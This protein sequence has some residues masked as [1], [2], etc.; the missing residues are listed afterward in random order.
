MEEN[1]D[2]LKPIIRS[3]LLALGRRAT[4]REFRS[5]YFNNEGESINTILQVG[6]HMGKIRSLL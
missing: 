5:E 6:L 2:E 1:T 4:E 3:I